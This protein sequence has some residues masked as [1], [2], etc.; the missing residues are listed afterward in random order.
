M[1]IVGKNGDLL[2]V[3]NEPTDGKV[4]CMKCNKCSTLMLSYYY[5][6]ICTSL[7]ELQTVLQLHVVNTEK[8]SIDYFH[9]HI[10]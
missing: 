2:Q 6:Y 5:I 4:I 7:I 8:N 3:A 9:V 1:V 10:H